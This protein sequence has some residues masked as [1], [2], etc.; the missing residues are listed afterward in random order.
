MAPLF[1]FIEVLFKLGWLKDLKK[2]VQP[3]IR[4]RI[5]AY[6]HA[7]GIAATESVAGTGRAATGPKKLK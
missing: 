4:D 6:R 1:V 7:K 2:A 5:R 3:L